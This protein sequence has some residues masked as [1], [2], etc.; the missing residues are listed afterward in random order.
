MLKKFRG[1]TAI[2]LGVSSVWSESKGLHDFIKLSKDKSLCVV[3]VGVSERIKKNL[4]KEIVVIDRTQNQKELAMLYNLADVNVNPTYADMFPTV[5]LESLACGTPVITHRTGGSPEA[6]TPDTGWV[7]EQG[8]VEGIAS[9]VKSLVIKDK[10]VIKD[11]R[12]S[13]RE[14]AEQ[15]FDKDKCFEKYL[16]LYNKLISWTR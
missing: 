13:C 12:K 5:N 6:V 8:D 11:Q 9:I 10:G 2:V 16:V 7:V 3:L 1:K 15:E 14:R 4:P